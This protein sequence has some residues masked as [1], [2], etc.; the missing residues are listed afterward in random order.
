MQSNINLLTYSVTL[1][2]ASFVNTEQSVFYS[3]PVSAGAI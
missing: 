1:M 2:S 3:V